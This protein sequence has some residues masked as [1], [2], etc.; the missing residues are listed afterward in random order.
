MG[1]DV[2]EQQLA[3]CGGHATVLPAT[4]VEAA[5]EGGQPGQSKLLEDLAGAGHAE[6]GAEDAA[7]VGVPAADGLWG[8]PVS[9]GHAGVE[10]SEGALCVASP[11]APHGF[12][13]LARPLACGLVPNAGLEPYICGAG[14]AAGSW[15]A[16]FMSPSC[17]SSRSYGAFSSSAKGGGSFVSHG[18]GLVG[19]LLLGLCGR[20]NGASSACAA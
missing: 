14:G 10:P 19:T 20:G 7:W 12:V 11:Q 9:V 13:A 15:G 6:H 5:E 8:H 2:V 4:A 3:G 1:A 17:R 16:P 18:T